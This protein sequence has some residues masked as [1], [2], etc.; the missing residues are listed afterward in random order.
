MHH[1]TCCAATNRSARQFTAPGGLGRTTSKQRMFYARNKEGHENANEAIKYT[2]RN[3]RASC[4]VSYPSKLFMS[5]NRKY[6][7]I[8]R[9]R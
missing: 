1:S 3:S 9:T 5:I 6:E 2:E 7:I 4:A 8:N